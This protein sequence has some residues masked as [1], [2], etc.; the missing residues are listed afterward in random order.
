[1][2][3]GSIFPIRTLCYY[4]ERSTRPMATLTP[5]RSARFSFAVHEP[6]G[7]VG[8]IVPWLSGSTLATSP[9]GF[10]QFGFARDRSLHAIDKYA[11]L[12]SVSITDTL[13]RLP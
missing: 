4:A 9:P 12:Q 13:T 6:L 7:V 10:E 5:R 3:R 11:D 1:M 8:V 2:S